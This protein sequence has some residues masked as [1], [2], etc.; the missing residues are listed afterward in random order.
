MSQL[1]LIFK[2]IILLNLTVLFLAC[3]GTDSNVSEG[4]NDDVDNEGVNIPFASHQATEVTDSADC[5]TESNAQDTIT[6]EGPNND[7]K[8]L[9]WNCVYADEEADVPGLQVSTYVE[10]RS[11]CFK[12]SGTMHIPGDGFEACDEI[13]SF[14]EEPNLEV[15][16]YAGYTNGDPGHAVFQVSVESTGNLS[17]IGAEYKVYRQLP[18][19]NGFVHASFD[20]AEITESGRGAIAPILPGQKEA[21]HYADVEAEGIH[22]S[23][24][25][26]YLI[27]GTIIETPVSTFDTDQPPTTGGSW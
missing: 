24:A 14:P 1:R 2:T 22:S 12:M 19:E 10:Q 7:V 21:I 26:V 3:G 16:V 27:D 4:A 5:L 8:Y 25:Q 15:T 17:V 18:I 11:S 20:Y 6:I 13:F 9:G 23:Y